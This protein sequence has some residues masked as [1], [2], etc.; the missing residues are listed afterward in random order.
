MTTGERIKAARKSK[1]I[2]QAELAKVSGL[3]LSSIQ[4]YESGERSPTLGA[5]KRISDA[6][7]VSFENLVGSEA[8]LSPEEWAETGKRISE[9]FLKMLILDDFDKLNEYGKYR[10]H[11]Y[12]SDLASME[13]YTTQ[14][15]EKLDKYFPEIPF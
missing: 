13:K 2:T 10:A 8:Q 5:I 3:G 14:D 1:K 9:G 6:L 11:E 15:Q 7:D 4:R 12:V